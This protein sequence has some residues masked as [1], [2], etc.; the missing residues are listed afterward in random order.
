MF[1]G[2]GINELLVPSKNSRLGSNGEPLF[3]FA[4][5]EVHCVYYIYITQSMYMYSIYTV[6][7]VYVA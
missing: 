1:G 2:K 4:S 7:C 3:L 5:D 6:H